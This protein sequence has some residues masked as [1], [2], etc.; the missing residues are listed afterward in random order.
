FF[1]DK[2]YFLSCSLS[3]GVHCTLAESMAA[4]LMPL[5]RAWKGAKNLFP[6]NFLFNTP[7]DARTIL[8]DHLP[9]PHQHRAFI[10]EN[11]PEAR[12]LGEL[13]AILEV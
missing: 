12:M 3:E 4:G 10:A 5:I 1:A 2:D 13:D 9:T 11:C 8:E 6:E 7:A